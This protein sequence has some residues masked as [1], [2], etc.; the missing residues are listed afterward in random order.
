MSEKKKRQSSIVFTRQDGKAVAIP[1]RDDPEGEAQALGAGLDELVKS[2][3]WK[4]DD[5]ELMAAE[6][7]YRELS[8]TPP[9]QRTRKGTV[10]NGRPRNEH[11]RA[12]MPGTRQ[13]GK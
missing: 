12:K 3:E 5:G 10:A 6:E 8:Y 4:P 7:F 1:V 11:A 13:G 2:G 9:E